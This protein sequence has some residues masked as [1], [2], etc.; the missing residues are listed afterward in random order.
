GP[1]RGRPRV[2]GRVPA[3]GLRAA[4]EV[5]DGA[6]PHVVGVRQPGLVVLARRVAVRCARPV[7]RPPLDVATV[8]GAREAG[9]PEGE[10][11]AERRRL[12]DEARARA[13]R[14]LPLVE[15]EPARDDHRVALVQR[16]RDVARRGLPHLD[17]EPERAAVDPLAALAVEVPPRLRDAEAREVVP[18]LRAEQRGG[19]R[20]EAGQGDRDVTGH[21]ASWGRRPGWSRPPPQ[22]AAGAVPPSGVVPC[23]VDAGAP[24][25]SVGSRSAPVSG[26]AGALSRADCAS[27][28]TCRWVSR[29]AC[30]G[31]PIAS[32]TTR[33]IAPRPEARTCCSRRRAS[34]RRTWSATRNAITAPRTATA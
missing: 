23:P 22:G 31:L 5:A 11:G 8:H 33:S 1:R 24:P 18:G 21:G 28:R 19:R 6:V 3:V 20:D 30:V 12:D 27:S 2:P 17:R 14:A 4:R 13:E 32:C 26:A 7:L 10:V 25:G 29:S 15:R 9:L 16:D 34:A